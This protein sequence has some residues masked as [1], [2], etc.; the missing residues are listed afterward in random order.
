MVL[1][2]VLKFGLAAGL[3]TSVFAAPQMEYLNRGV[4]VANVGAGVLV[5][6]RLLGS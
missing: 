2:S 6:W 5:S 1:K 3:A 4:S